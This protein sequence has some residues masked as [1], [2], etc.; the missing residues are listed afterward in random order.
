MHGT[1]LTC[2]ADLMGCRPSSE[3]FAADLT[4]GSLFLF[5]NRRQ[6]DRIV[7]LRFRTSG[8]RRG[9]S[10]LSGII[11]LL[12]EAGH[13]FEMPSRPPD[14]SPTPNRRGRTGSIA[15]APSVAFPVVSV[16]DR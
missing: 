8:G 6:R 5:V 1:D 16:F 10:G 7:H 9:F 4:D 11:D 12:L 15:A 2:V 13:R 3:K 14:G